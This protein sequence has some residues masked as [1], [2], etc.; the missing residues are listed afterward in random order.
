[1]AARSAVPLRCSLVALLLCA[2]AHGARK[3][4]VAD[5]STN[6]RVITKDQIAESGL[7]TAWDLLRRYAGNL[8]ADRRD[9]SPGRLQNRGRSSIYLND[10]PVVFVDG[11]RLP[12][13][14]NLQY[15]PAQD[16]DNIRIISGITGTTYYGTNAG[17]GVILVQTKSSN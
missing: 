10:G 7:K 15:V 13:V 16:I 4:P 2:C 12:D 17:G 11:V 8:T 5:Q 6:E 1:M 3:P 9:G 14:R